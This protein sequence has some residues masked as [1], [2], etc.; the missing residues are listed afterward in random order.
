MIANK[1]QKLAMFA[2]I[3]FLRM[4]SPPFVRRAFL[5][6][7]PRRRHRANVSAELLWRRL[8]QVLMTKRESGEAPAEAS[9]LEGT[10]D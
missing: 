3:V 4:S 7:S 2:L 8:D 6:G 9:R 1:S 5:G 10:Q